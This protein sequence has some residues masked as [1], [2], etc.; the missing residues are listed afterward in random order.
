MKDNKTNNSNNIFQSVETD[1][2]DVDSANRK[3]VKPCRETF[4][5]PVK[6]QFKE[7]GFEMNFGIEIEF[8]HTLEHFL[9]DHK[10]FKPVVNVLDDLFK[11]VGLSLIRQSSDQEELKKVEWIEFG[12]NENE[13]IHRFKI[14]DTLSHAG[15]LVFDGTS[16][17]TSTGKIH[18]IRKVITTLKNG[19]V[20]RSKKCERENSYF[21]EGE[22]L[23][24]GSICLIEVKG[25]VD[26]YSFESD[27]SYFYLFTLAPKSTTSLSRHDEFG[28][29][30]D[31]ENIFIK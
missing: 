22:Y 28:I 10:Q 1:I 4:N 31:I 8:N 23:D 18:F 21:D 25:G 27:E 29:W 5:E 24:F 30:P 2:G 19:I 7:K 9:F 15:K 26:V 3:L 17:N 14:N 16:T 20:V 6:Q 13:Y 12:Y 11:I